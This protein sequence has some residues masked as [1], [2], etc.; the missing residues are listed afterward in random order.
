MSQL[1]MPGKC[2]NYSIHG[3]KRQKNPTPI[4]KFEK[5]SDARARLV[6]CA[7][8]GQEL[9]Q[10]DGLKHLLIPEYR[11]INSYVCQNHNMHNREALKKISKNL[12]LS[13]K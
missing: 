8:K 3:H 13:P 1:F 10:G 4:P 2:Q 6:F 7:S 12:G 9:Q 11:S 5:K